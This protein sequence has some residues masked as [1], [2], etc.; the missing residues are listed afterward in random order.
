MGF[1]DKLRLQNIVPGTSL[2]LGFTGQLPK[3]GGSD[4]AKEMIRMYK[5]L[6]KSQPKQP[7]INQVAQS[8]ASPR[9]EPTSGPGRVNFV[10]M[11]LTDFQKESL[12]QKERDSLRRAEGQAQNR[13]LTSQKNTLAEW[14][15]RNPNKKFVSVR[16]GN[17][18]AF[19]PVT[20][21]AEDTGISSGTLTES[22]R[23]NMMDTNRDEDR[24]D[25]QQA[26][27]ESQARSFRN[28][29]RLQDDRQSNE[30]EDWGN[31]IQTYNPDGTP[32]PVVQINNRGESRPV[33]G[34]GAIKPKA[35]DV[36]PTQQGHGIT[37]RIRE[38]LN[39]KPE[40]ED[41][42][43]V[44]NQRVHPVGH[45]AGIWGGGLDAA[46]RETILRNIYGTG[47]IDVNA[48]P[49]PEYEEPEEVEQPKVPKASDVGLDKLKTNQKYQ[50]N[51]GKVGTYLGNGRFRIEG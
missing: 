13:S 11:G 42:I 9:Q 40:W 16:G 28:Q 12:A 15:A 20:G 45:G 41:Y 14:K 36:Q 1:V 38:L 39:R 3:Y 10:D 46:T 50:L 29:R 31:A 33:T 26:A 6:V 48:E 25:R 23:L 30:S 18:M 44:E 47:P 22:E 35:R 2:N 5:N 24:E 32:G 17:V 27:R 8:V 4:P 34:V 21:E 19:D 7:R 51:N 43:D 49:V 37:N